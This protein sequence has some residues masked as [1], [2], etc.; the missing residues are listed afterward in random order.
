M[1][2]LQLD[3]LAAPPDPTRD[4]ILALVDADPVHSR[5]RA[6]IIDAIERAVRSDGTVSSNAWRPLIPTFVYNR[7][8]GSTVHALIR[9]GVLQPTGDYERST[10]THGRNGNKVNPVY[11]W[12]A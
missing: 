3:L 4:A 2:T 7:C 8:V 1:T 12:A 6:A 9:A 10:D 11:R 5:D